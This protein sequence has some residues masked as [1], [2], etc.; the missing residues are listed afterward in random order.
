MGRF[1][2]ADEFASTGQ[3]IL[4]CNMFVYCLDNPVS[5]T[6][7]TGSMTASFA[8][9]ACLNDNAGAGGGGAGLVIGYGLI[10]LIEAVTKAIGCT[11]SRGINYI[12]NCI[13][14]A[15]SIIETEKNRNGRLYAVYFML[16]SAGEVQY[17]GR[18][19][20]ENLTQR[21]NF[22]MR[23]KGLVGFRSLNNLTWDKARGAEEAGMLY[24]H[25]I[26][27]GVPYN[28]QIHGIAASNDFYDIFMN[29]IERYANNKLEEMMYH[30]IYG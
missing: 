5:G 4:G 6:D 17:V 24:F 28:N 13:S 30:L 25:T 29:A 26:H 20:Q 8:E 22:H 12:E 3:G 9:Q 7:A 15:E 14:Q 1:I 21:T 27:R 23:T 16:D 10:K 18:V 19:V 11:V 2:N